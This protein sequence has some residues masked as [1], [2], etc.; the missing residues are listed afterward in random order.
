[1]QPNAPVYPEKDMMGIYSS[2]ITIRDHIAIEA[3]KALITSG[4]YLG[5][6]TA[7]NPA[8]DLTAAH[9]YLFADALIA[10]SNKK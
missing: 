1:M 6:G 7:E 4:T 2:G 10:E 8:R 9:A 3:M 5:K